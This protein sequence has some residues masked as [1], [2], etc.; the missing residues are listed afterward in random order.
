MEGSSRHYSS[1][2][3][4]WASQYQAPIVTFASDVTTITSQVFKYRPRRFPDANTLLY[5]AMDLLRDVRR[6][7][8]E[9]HPVIARATT[10]ARDL[11][12]RFI[13]TWFATTG[14]S[15]Q[16]ENTLTLMDS[17]VRLFYIIFLSRQALDARTI[18]YYAV[19]VFSVH[20]KDI[21]GTNHLLPW[22]EVPQFC[23]QLQSGQNAHVS[24]NTSS[25][26]GHSG[27]LFGSD[28]KVETQHSQAQQEAESFQGLDDP[29]N[30]LL[31]PELAAGLAAN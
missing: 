25:S 18:S 5:E 15:V 22:M 13:A 23:W 27:A 7:L 12:D 10:E 30:F 8:R 14:L 26:F 9:N 24:N 6:L 11:A 1:F 19:D 3:Y 21:S 17:H 28:A 31:D 4:K 16:L 2:T 29:A 20:I